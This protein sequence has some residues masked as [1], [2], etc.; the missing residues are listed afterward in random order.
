MRM[1]LY[2][3][4]RKFFD[5]IVREYDSSKK[6]KRLGILLLYSIGIKHSFLVEFVISKV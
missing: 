1:E 4:D 5:K 6:I 2:Y 3:L